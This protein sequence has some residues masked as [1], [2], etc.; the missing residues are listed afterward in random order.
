LQGLV[1]G[2]VAQ[3]IVDRLEFIEVDIDDRELAVLAQVLAI[4]CSA[5]RRA[6]ASICRPA[7]SRKYSKMKIEMKLSATR[8][9]SSNLPRNDSRAPV[10]RS[11]TLYIFSSMV[12]RQPPGHEPYPV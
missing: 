2:L 4:S 6:A 10:R 5:Q 11:R 9:A 7:M 8:I 1:A 3:R 12:W